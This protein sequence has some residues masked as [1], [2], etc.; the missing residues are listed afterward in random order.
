MVA[1][2]QLATLRRMKKKQM[3]TARHLA[4]AFLMCYGAAIGAAGKSVWYEIDSNA[5]QISFTA[6][7]RVVKAQ[8]LFRKWD[9]KGRISGNFHVV[10]D[11]SIECASIDTDNDRRDNHLKGA[12]F[13]DC[14]SF[15]RHTFRVI[16]VKPDNT[17]PAKA[18]RFLVAGE[19]TIRDKTRN[20]ELTLQRE[21]AE[22]R[23]TLSGST[24]IDR[25]EF[26]IT[27]N[28]ALNPIEKTIRVDVRLVLNRRDR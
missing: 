23:P 18:A 5:S 24:F 8:G 19:L 1:K 3:I 22:Q 26:G 9:F 27:Y 4:L 13:F 10:G 11:L 7:S 21:G 6:K 25:E 28:S 14:A 2:T 12:D 15:P 16:G 17:N 20:V